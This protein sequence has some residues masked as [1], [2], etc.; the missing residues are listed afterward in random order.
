MSRPVRLEAL[1]PAA[2]RDSMRR[3]RRVIIP[4]GTLEYRAPHLPLGCDSI[5]LDRLADELSVRTGVPRAPVIPF[6]AHARGD[7]TSAGTAFLSRKTLHRVMNEL[8][9]AWEEDAG[10]EEAL[11][12]TVHAAEPHVEALSTIRTQGTVTVVDVLGFDLRHFLDAAEGNLHGGEVD[13]SL[14]LHVAPDLIRDAEAVARLKAS[15]AKGARILDYI[16]EQVSR[17][18][19]PHA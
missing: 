8:I 13:T 19:L 12:L 3:A 14:L 1:T 16:V 2:A 9:A 5:I 11:V 18:W 10:L 15:G 7:A 6:G 4:A 17:R